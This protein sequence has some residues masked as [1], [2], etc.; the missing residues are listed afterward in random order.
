MA[1]AAITSGVA[2]VSPPAAWRSAAHRAREMLNDGVPSG[3]STSSGCLVMGH[4]HLR[5]RVPAV[6]RLRR[7]SGRGAA[8]TGSRAVTTSIFAFV[9]GAIRSLAA[10]GRSCSLMSNSSTRPVMSAGRRQIVC[11]SRCCMRMAACRASRSQETGRRVICSPSISSERKVKSPLS[12][13]HAYGSQSSTLKLSGTVLREE[14]AP[15]RQKPFRGRRLTSP[16]CTAVRPGHSRGDT[17]HAR[18]RPRGGTHS[19]R[20]R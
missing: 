18:F 14:P 2:G 17:N 10:W 9:L 15:A 6:L 16:N 5:P 3:G 20:A 13:D 19:A 11:S 8:R 1:G 4:H 7:E 12:G